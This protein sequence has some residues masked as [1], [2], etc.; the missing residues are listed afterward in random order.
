[1]TNF[2]RARESVVEFYNQRGTA[3]QCIKEGKNMVEW[4]HL[5][6]HRF[7]GNAVR[8]R[9]FAPVYNLANS[10]RRLVLTGPVKHWSLTTPREKL[11]KIGARA[12]RHARYMALQMAEVAVP[13]GLF[14]AVLE[15]IRR[16]APVPD[17][18]D[19]VI[20]APLRVQRQPW[21]RRVC[22]NGCKAAA[23][24]IRAV[25]SHEATTWCKA[26]EGKILTE[27]PQR[28]DSPA[29][30]GTNLAERNPFAGSLMG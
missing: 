23:Q 2:G 29:P 25:P 5:S 4:T 18:M 13:W 22:S 14:E 3:G 17:L 26:G 27:P 7:M 21:A 11:V 9:L 28:P 10:I 15:R 16:L 19:H 1:V 24:P 6:C 12:V 20:C 30:S 8:L